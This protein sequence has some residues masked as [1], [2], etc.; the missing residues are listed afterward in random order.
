MIIPTTFWG[1]HAFGTHM[2][3]LKRVIE[4]TTGPVLEMGMGNYSTPF[5]H[6]ICSDRELLSIDN[7]IE[8]VNT[9]INY[10]SDTHNIIK[11][12]QNWDDVDGYIQSKRWGVVFIDHHPCERR[13][14]DIRLLM[15]NA[16]YIVI[17]DTEAG[18]LAADKYNYEPTL[19]LFRYRWNFTVLNPNTTVV[20]MT[21]PIPPFVLELENLNFP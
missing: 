1:R 8:W 9:F 2:P 5:L 21:D 13:V 10:N 6:D 12:D 14:V 20:S 7:D 15:N 16:K 17:H 19:S 4:V 11:V 18:A 3:V